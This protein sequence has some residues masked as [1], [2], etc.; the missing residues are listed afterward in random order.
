MSQFKILIDEREEAKRNFEQLK[1]E[2]GSVNSG[3]G[4]PSNG[5]SN[6]Q[7]KPPSANVAETSEIQFAA[8][9]GQNLPSFLPGS[10]PFTGEPQESSP[11]R[12][13]TDMLRCVVRLLCCPCYYFFGRPK[14]SRPN[15]PA[16]PMASPAA[17]YPYGH[18]GTAYEN[19]ETYGP[20]AI[21]EFAMPISTIAP[22]SLPAP[23]ELDSYYHS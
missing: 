9:N 23:A 3:I 2:I 1:A 7:Q 8:Y 18:V 16:F 14:Q 17:P 13:L 19:L 6:A 21:F 20:E 15:A 5:S 11:K 10:M 4:E 12:I 22:L